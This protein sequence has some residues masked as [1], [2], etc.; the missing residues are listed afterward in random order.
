VAILGNFFHGRAFYT[1][2]GTLFFLK[3]DCVFA[4]FF[5]LEGCSYTGPPPLD[6]NR[7]LE[8]FFPRFSRRGPAVIDLPFSLFY[9]EVGEAPP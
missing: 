8:A 6:C 3:D 1:L 2:S 9:V 5:L 7:A 4:Y